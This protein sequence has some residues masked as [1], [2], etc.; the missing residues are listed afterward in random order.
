MPLQFCDCWKLQS[1][2]C[3]PFHLCDCWKLQSKHADCLF[4]SVTTRNS[5][6]N[7]VCLSG[8]GCLSQVPATLHGADVEQEFQGGCPG[9]PVRSSTTRLQ[10]RMWWSEEGRVAMSGLAANANKAKTTASATTYTQGASTTAKP[11]NG[12]KHIRICTALWGYSQ[13]GIALYKFDL[14]LLLLKGACISQ[15]CHKTGWRVVFTED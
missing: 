3:L 9:P 12:S 14:L 7:T 13:C 2:H 6:S 5:S 4:I 11:A 1:K 15:S 8:A 10:E